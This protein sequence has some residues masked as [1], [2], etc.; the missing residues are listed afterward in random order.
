M[1]ALPPH[2]SRAAVLVFTYRTKSGGYRSK[3]V[4]IS[5]VP[6]GLSVKSRMLSVATSGRLAKALGA[7]SAFHSLIHA[8]DADSLA[9]EDMLK[10]VSRFELDSVDQDAQV[11]VD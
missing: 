7:I 3:T 2:E 6:D 8:S 9:V 1:S 5:Y 11:C 10:R 4:F